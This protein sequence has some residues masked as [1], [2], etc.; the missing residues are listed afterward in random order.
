MAAVLLVGSG[1]VDE[2]AVLARVGHV[3]DR[4]QVLAAVDEHERLFP[5]Q[6]KLLFI[7]LDVSGLGQKH[8]GK[9]LFKAF[10]RPDG[11]QGQL[12]VGHIRPCVAAVA[13]SP[14]IRIG[15]VDA[16]VFIQL[17][18]NQEVLGP[19]NGFC[20]LLSWVRVRAIRHTAVT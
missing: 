9:L 2:A 18:F 20:V 19:G 10:G 11:F 17:K 6:A 15:L 1:F 5:V 3:I 7:G 4:F 16:F 12:G 8:A 14:V 13:D